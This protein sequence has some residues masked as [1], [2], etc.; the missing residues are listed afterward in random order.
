MPVR[1]KVRVVAMQELRK[2]DRS[3][4]MR[5][6]VGLLLAVV[7]A[8][9]LASVGV[10]LA[11]NPPGSCTPTAGTEN[12]DVLLGTEVSDTCDGKGGAD[13]LYGRKGD[14]ILKGG[15][16]NDNFKN[17]AGPNRAGENVT[18]GLRGGEGNDKVYGQEGDDDLMGHGGN[19][20]LDDSST[21]GDWDR[22]FGDSGD[23]NINVVDNDTRDE[24]SCGENTD[25]TSGDTD[26]AKIDV[27]KSGSTITS[28][29]KVYD[30]E[31]VKDQAGTTVAVEQLP[32][33]KE[34]AAAGKKVVAPQTPA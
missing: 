7:L 32:Q 34:A 29:D 33:Y 16:G 12:N 3:T 10:V 14:D 27:F 17:I 8:M 31:V 26:T 19:D 24:V 1:V 20:T 18:A 15:P 2:Q 11:A 23:D 5:S 30:C 13:A 22:T 21:S 25:P 9:L 6:R 4:T 28:A